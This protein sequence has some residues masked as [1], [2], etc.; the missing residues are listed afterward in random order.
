MTQIAEKNT[1]PHDY[2]E[3]A[4]ENGELVMQP[5]CAC[6]NALDE[7]YVCGKCHRR[8]QCNQILCND[9]ATLERVKSYIRKSSQFSAFKVKLAGAV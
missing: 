4:L 5:Y 8:C 9:E 7:D 3:A 2:Y 6:G 1:P